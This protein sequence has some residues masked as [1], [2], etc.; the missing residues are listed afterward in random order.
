MMTRTYETLGYVVSSLD[1]LKVLDCVLR[2]VPGADQPG[3][4]CPLDGEGTV[5]TP[6]FRRKID[7]ESRGKSTPIGT[8]AESVRPCAMRVSLC[9]CVDASGSKAPSTW[10]SV[11]SI[12]SDRSLSC[13]LTL[14]LC[15]CAQMR[16]HMWRT[17][18]D[19]CLLQSFPTAAVL[20]LPNTETL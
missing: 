15:V 5:V 17:E 16:T 9:P 13:A 18:E 12:R 20:S 10:T 7:S 11:E 6:I 19:L 1:P 2:E 8:A 14:F 4:C 3:L